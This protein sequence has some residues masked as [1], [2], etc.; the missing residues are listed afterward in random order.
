LIR[1]GIGYAPG[2]H[3]I[4]MQTERPT[5]GI[6][7]YGY[8]FGRPIT[9]TGGQGTLRKSDAHYDQLIQARKNL[10]GQVNSFSDWLTML[11]ANPYS[12]PAM[13]SVASGLIIGGLSL[14]PSARRQVVESAGHVASTAIT[15]TA[16]VA[17]EFTPG[18]ITDIGGI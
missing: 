2:Q 17:E 8:Q 16:E 12:I 1:E 4:A 10:M 9:Y 13:L 6:S 7:A 18:R 14:D 15:A 3:D 11:L 5:G